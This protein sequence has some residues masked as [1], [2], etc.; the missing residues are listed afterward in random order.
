MCEDPVAVL[1]F[2]ALCANTSDIIGV[3]ATATIIIAA[4][5]IVIF[6]DCCFDIIIIGYNLVEYYCY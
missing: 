4:K 3:I 5:G 1:L 2:E 6:V